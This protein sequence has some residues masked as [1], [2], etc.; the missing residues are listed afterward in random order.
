MTRLGPAALAVAALGLAACS[1]FESPKVD[2]KAEKKLPPLEVPPD[3]STP[4]REER[5]QIPD[6][7]KPAGPTTFSAYNAERNATA[8]PGSTGILPEIDKIRIDRRHALQDG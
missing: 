4:G 3:L 7:S 1:A 2:Y 8:K 6:S 5:Y